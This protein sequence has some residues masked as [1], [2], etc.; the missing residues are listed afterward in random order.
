[1]ARKSADRGKDRERTRPSG[2]ELCR[3]LRLF[4]EEWKRLLQKAVEASMVPAPPSSELTVGGKRSA[5]QD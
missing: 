5:L 2:I 1:M 3:E 4:K